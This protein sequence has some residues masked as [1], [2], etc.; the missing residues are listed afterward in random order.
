MWLLS[1]NS[2]ATSAYILSNFEI[3]CDV[4]SDRLRTLLQVAIKCACYAVIPFTI[5]TLYGINLSEINGLPE[6]TW[7]I[8]KLERV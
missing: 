1:R 7:L 8:L 4:T 5:C 2:I 6:V 3:R